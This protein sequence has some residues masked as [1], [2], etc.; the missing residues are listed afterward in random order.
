M[1]EFTRSMCCKFYP[2][3]IPTHGY[4][5]SGVRIQLRVPPSRHLKRE[6]D[7]SGCN[8]I[9][10]KIEI[11][12]RKRATI[13]HTLRFN[14]LS[15]ACRATARGGFFP[16]DPCLDNVR[17]TAHARGNPDGVGR[18]IPGARPAH[19]AS[20]EIFDGG[21]FP[22]HLKYNVGADTLTHAAPHTSFSVKLQR[23][24]AG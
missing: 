22:F 5:V 11:L 1:L 9:K 4:M 17:G 6:T 8:F 20:V 19:Q 7:K 18:T 3:F 13:H 10:G 2:D 24:Y 12:I 21:L 15:A 23:R 16:L 14:R